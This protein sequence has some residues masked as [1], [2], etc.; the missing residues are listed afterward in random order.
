MRCPGCS[1]SENF[2]KKITQEIK[3]KSHNAT[4]YKLISLHTTLIM[5]GNVSRLAAD[6]D[7]VLM[8]ATFHT[9]ET[10]LSA[11][12]KRFDILPD[13]APALVDPITC[14]TPPSTK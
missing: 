5:H 13:F 9:I 14:T 8:K 12:G 6:M 1:I 4:C 2:N 7:V 11:F 10:Q 3:K